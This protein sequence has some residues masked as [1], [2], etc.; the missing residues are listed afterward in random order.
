[1]EINKRILGL[2]PVEKASSGWLGGSLLKRHRGARYGELKVTRDRAES[3][4]WKGSSLN[5][6]RSQRWGIYLPHCKRQR[7]G[8]PGE[9]SVAF[10][11]SNLLARLRVKGLLWRAKRGVRR[12]LIDSS[13]QLL[14]F[15]IKEGRRFSLF[16]EKLWNV[17]C[18]DW[19]L[20]LALATL[21]GSW[22]SFC[23]TC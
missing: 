13:L 7:A 2:S 3:P 9:A 10:P 11:P 8:T 16:L 1:M 18:F 19:W 6:E 12:Q 15:P 23:N 22:C 20:L 21:F 14:L 4:E 17:N 5:N